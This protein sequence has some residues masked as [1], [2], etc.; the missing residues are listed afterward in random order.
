MA[1]NLPQDDYQK[2]GVRIPRELH[3]ALHH[4]AREAGR[5][6]NSELIHRLAASFEE[7][8]EIPEPYRGMIAAEAERQ[9]IS[10]QGALLALLAEALDP[11]SQVP[12]LK[13]EVETLRTAVKALEKAQEVTDATR[14]VLA[15]VHRSRE[16]LHDAPGAKEL[17]GIADRI[18][19]DVIHG[20]TSDL[21]KLLQKQLADMAA[22]RSA[23]KED[24]KP[25][26]ANA[27]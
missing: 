24:A 20:T 4:A 27:R 17:F 6:Y 18:A 19:D 5:S 21:A 23:N 7:S 15:L 12:A 16:T 25:H 11:S 22:S 3:E 2:Q 1:T 14:V 13:R 10:F 8:T 9:G 26:K